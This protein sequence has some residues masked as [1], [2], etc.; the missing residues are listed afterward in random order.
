[1]RIDYTELIIGQVFRHKYILECKIYKPIFLYF[2]L[3]Y[4]C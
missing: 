4:I 2:G 1:M 3:R